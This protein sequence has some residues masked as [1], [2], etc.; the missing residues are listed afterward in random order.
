MD[1]TRGRKLALVS[2]RRKKVK[3]KATIEILPNTHPIWK[4]ILLM[5][6]GITK[7]VTNAQITFQDA[8]RDCV[9]SR[10]AEFGISAPR[11]YGMEAP[12]ILNHKVSTY[13]Q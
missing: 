10:S 6:Y 2:G 1:R 4:W 11:R 8:P 12:P 7:L 13:L 9:F 3:I 5:M